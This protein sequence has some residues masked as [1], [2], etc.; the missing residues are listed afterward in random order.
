MIHYIT[1]QGIGDAWVGNELRVVHSMGIP[2]VL[3]AL[4]RPKSTYFASEWAEEVERRTRYL[5]PLPPV[6]LIGAVVAAPWRF[7]SRFFAA[8]GNAL[9]GHRESFRG[10]IASLAHLFV[11]CLWAGRLRR[12][13]VSLIHSQWIHSGGTVGMYG[14]WL[15]GVPFSFTGH[16]ADLFR[17]RVALKDKIRRAEFIICI[18]TFHRDLFRSLGA[19]EEQLAI[20]YCGLDLG[21]FVALPRETRAGGPARILSAGR[22]VEKKGFTDLIEAC[23]ILA[24]R[25]VSFR[26]TIAGSG[27]LEASLRRQVEDANLADRVIVTGEALKQERIPEFMRDGDLFCLPCVWAADGDV[28]GLPQLLMEAMACGLPSLSTR[29]VGIPDLVRHGETGLLV[30]PHD[31]PALAEAIQSLIDDPERAAR[32][33]EAGRAW[34]HQR[35]DLAD[36]LEPLLSRFRERLDQGD[37]PPES[38]NSD[39]PAEAVNAGAAT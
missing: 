11:A 14:A 1:T 12:D 10:R 32:L 31:P 33:A 22:L 16:A 34:V 7:G 28:D 23:R 27:P 29:L 36:C 6:E 19:R 8:L 38:A 35:F 25:G 37:K 4:R 15:L 39:C 13:G 26:C 18:S 30:E 21:H 9:L 5:Y 24:E 20:A 2:Y 17:E 3:H